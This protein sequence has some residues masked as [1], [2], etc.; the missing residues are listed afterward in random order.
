MPHSAVLAF[1][2]TPLFVN[3]LFDAHAPHGESN[4]GDLHIHTHTHRHTDCT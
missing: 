1:T 3:I 2:T 4:E